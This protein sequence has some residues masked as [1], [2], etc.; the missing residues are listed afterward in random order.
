MT[1]TAIYPQ[2]QLPEGFSDEELIAGLDIPV[3]IAP[4]PDGRVVITE[5]FAGRALIAKLTAGS[6]ATEILTISDVNPEGNERGLLGV[7]VDP[8]YPERPFLYFY[9]TSKGKTIRLTRY[10][11]GPNQTAIDPK[12]RL[13]ILTDIPDNAWNHNGGS[14][15]FGPDGMLYVSIGDDANSCSAQRRD[16]LRG[17]MLRLD[18]RKLPT[19]GESSVD[20]ALLAPE[21]NPFADSENVNERLVFVYGLRNP[22]RFHIDANTGDLVIADVGLLDFEEIDFV[23]DKTGAGSNFGWPYF[24]GP[25]PRAEVSCRRDSSAKFVGP[26]AYYDRTGSQASVISLCLYR[27]TES[28]NLNWGEAY[29]GDYFYHDYYSGWVRRISRGVNGEWAPAA[30]APGQVDSLNWATGLNTCA[31]SFIGSD[32]ALYYLKQFDHTFSPGTGQV[33]RIAR[34]R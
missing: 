30:P 25:A 2:A 26:V 3:S 15:R 28:G 8:E 1:A 4:L 7:A 22:F 27:N 24:E 13:D 18:V 10:T 11:F 14:L 19:G 20:K 9:F 34:V 5:Q 31:D 12:S 17:M 16:D 29:E 23:S 32:G 6:A 21:D 33:R